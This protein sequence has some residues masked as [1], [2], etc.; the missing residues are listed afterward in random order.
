MDLA[1]KAGRTF[2]HEF[3][4]THDG[5][6][7]DTTPY[8]FTCEIRRHAEADDVLAAPTVLKVAPNPE[9]KFTINLSPAQTTALLDALAALGISAGPNVAVFDVKANAAGAIPP[10][11]TGWVTVEVGVTE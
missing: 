1:I 9:G 5:Q 8:L 7:V 6:P 10:L 3:T 11:P 2:S 4:W